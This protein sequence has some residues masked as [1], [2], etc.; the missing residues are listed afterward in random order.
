[1]KPVFITPKERE[2]YNKIET[3]TKCY[4]SWQKLKKIKQLQET[5]GEFELEL[6]KGERLKKN[7]L[8]DI[9]YE[10]EQRFSKESAEVAVEATTKIMKKRFEC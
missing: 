6:E 10:V 3:K 7:Q 5:V 2:E 8:I 1:M 4:T 9:F